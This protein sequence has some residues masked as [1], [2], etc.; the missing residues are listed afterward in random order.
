MQKK[1]LYRTNMEL[2]EDKQ[3][4]RESISVLI[5]KR[6]MQFINLQEKI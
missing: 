1:M 3:S 2:T 5:K 6:N 4:F